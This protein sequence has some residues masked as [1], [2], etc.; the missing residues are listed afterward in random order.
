VLKAI[1]QE[2]SNGTAHVFVKT[3]SWFNSSVCIQLLL[4]WS[5][6]VAVLAAVCR[7]DVFWFQAETLQG[8][9]NEYIPLVRAAR[10]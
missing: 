3:E 5:P 4:L 8:L 2:H 6:A 10:P 7:G 9:V 1:F